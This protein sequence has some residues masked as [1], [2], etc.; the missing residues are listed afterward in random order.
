MVS[1]NRD[2]HREL[3][4]A[5]RSRGSSR[6]PLTTGEVAASLDCSRG[7]AHGGL[8]E[9]ASEGVLETK[10]VD[11]RSRIWWL[12]DDAGAT[13][14]APGFTPDAE[15]GSDADREGVVIVDAEE[16]VAWV[17]DA[18]SE[19]FGVDRSAAVGRARDEFLRAALDDRA[20]A[21]TVEELAA[22]AGDA[23]GDDPFAF[24]L[25]P[26]AD[27][28]VTRLRHAVEPIDGGRYAGGHVEFFTDVTDR[29]GPTPADDGDEERLFRSLV[30]ATTEY[31]IFT[32]DPD[33]HV[34]S[35][36]RGAER[37]KGY[38][39][40]EILGE[41]FSTFYTDEDVEAGVPKEN[42]SQALQEGSVE[43]EGWRVRADGS[44]F[45][46]NVTTTP[47]R[48]DDGELRGFAKVTRDITDRHEWERQIQEERNLLERTLDVVPSR[49]G[50]VSPDGEFLRVNDG[51]DGWFGTD[52]DDGSYGLAS[53]D[54]Y[55]ASGDRVPV[56]ER[57]YVEVFETGEPVSD[58][59]CQVELPDGSRRWFAVNAAPLTDDDG[60][61]EEVVVSGSDVTQIREQAE[62]L[63]ARHDDLE[64]E[65]DEMFE[66]VS[67]AF[68]G[69]DDEWRFTYVNERAEDVLG[70]DE[71]EFLGATIWDVFEDA[72]GTSSEERLRE[73]METQ[74][75]VHF[76]AHY[77]PLETCF[78]V[79]A[80]P[81]E[82]GLSVYFRDVTERKRRERV[83]E[84]YETL[85][86]ESQDV[87]AVIDPDG[88]FGYLP[89]ST[90]HVL[91]YE[92][93]ELAGERAFDYV[94]PDDR[95]EIRERLG[96][97]VEDP[98]R[99][100]V[101]EFRFR[102]ADGSWVV[103]EARARNL[104]DDPTIDGVVVY[105][106][107]VTERKERE[108]YQRELYEVT[109]SGD[110]PFDEKV[111]QL[112]DLGRE[113]FGLDV[114][115]LTRDEGDELRV[116]NAAGAVDVEE[117]V[118]TVSPDPGH[119]CR[120]SIG[121]DGPV[122]VEDVVASGWEEDPLYRDLGF[123]CYLGVEV[124]VGNDRYGTLCF[125]DREARADSFDDAQRTFLDLMGQ[126]VSYELERDQFE[127]TLQTLH[128]SSRELIRSETKSDVSRTVID[129]ATSVL[130]LEGVAAYRYDATD[131]ALVLDER[132]VEAG[133]MRETLPDFPA[134]HSSIVG[135]TFRE[136]EANYYDDVRESEH[137]LADPAEVDMEAGLFVPMD[138]HGVLVVGWPEGEAPDER[139]RR[140]VRILAA[141]AEAAYE[142]VERERRREEAE[143]RYRTLAENFP[144][145]AV[146]VYDDSLEFTLVEGAIWEDV[147]LDPDALEGEHVTEVV[148]DASADVESLYRDA[149]DG[150]PGSTEVRFGTDVFRV[151]ALP[152][153]DDAGDVSGGL[154]FAIDVTERV[155]RERELEEYETI[156]ETVQDGVYVLDEEFRFEKVNEAYAE[157]TGYDREELLGSHCSLVLGDEVSQESARRV[158][159]T[160]AEHSDGATVEADIHRADGTRL[161]AESNFSALPGNGGTAGR[162]GVVRDLTERIERER[163]LEESRRRYRT[164]VEN[165]PN[166]AVAMVDREMRYLTVGGE[167]I[168]EPNL[169]ADALVGT[170]V[171]EELPPELAEVFVPHYRR[172]LDGVETTDEIE[173]EGT[174]YKLRFV[175]VRDDD[176]EV[177]A[178]LG[179]SQDV[180]ARVEREREL[181]TRVDQHGVVADL[182]RRALGNPELDDLFADAV[183]RVAD[184]LDSEYCKVLDLDRESEELRLRS[185]VGWNEGYVGTATVDVDRDSQAGYTLLADEPVVV[186]DMAAE[187]RFAGP[188]LLVDHAVESGI[189]VVIGSPTD[190]WGVLGI[191][192]TEPREFSENDA[193]F[194]QSVA[195]VLATAID[196][197]EREVELEEQ[198]AHL[199]A[200]DDINGVV[201]DINEALV[202]QSTRDQI[203]RTVCERLADS[204]SYRFAWIAAVD[205]RTGTVEPRAEAG[206]DGYLD[207]VDVSVDDDAPEGQGPTGRAARTTEIQ[208]TNDALADPAYEP[209]RDVAEA[210]DFR[211]TAAIP[212]VYGDNLYGVLGVYTDR[213]GAF[214]DEE[215][216]VVAQLGEIVGHAIAAV[217]RK[218]A[219]MSDEVVEL[220]IRMENLLA[221]VGYAGPTEGRATFEDV[222]AIGDDEFLQYGTAVG[223]GIDAVEKLVDELPH[224]EECT[225]VGERFDEHRFELRL[226]EPPLVSAVADRGGYIDEAV[227]EDGSM[228]V[229]IHLPPTADVRQ[230]VDAIQDAYETAEMV[231]RQQVHRDDEER[232]IERALTEELTERQRAALEASFHAGFFEWPRESSGEEVAESLDVSAPT[233]HQ[234]L[235][236][237][238]QKL[239]ETILS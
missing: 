63:A 141:N 56:E 54:V 142:R 148:D 194:V 119:Y 155:E 88:T 99:S 176:C 22:R 52:G 209:W 186:E 128:E 152:I 76:E 3:L 205:P 71:G 204:D 197:R 151:W 199:A 11:E 221:E 189:S 27:E 238:Q 13:G 185:G 159:E 164:V 198:R 106:R 81:S 84:R 211:S 4:A 210:Y 163:E 218:R 34:I 49:I 233:F 38:D 104:L 95:E 160:I 182:G 85:F 143:R 16:T 173:V 195:N 12:A 137:L 230:T 202:E 124:T 20:D 130:D 157:M 45:W 126:W 110:V 92:P 223:G 226:S 72:A 111:D 41:H 166:G 225:V 31:A 206:V 112:I 82:S 129:A 102:H 29:T 150:T 138:D 1:R 67:N 93:G 87:N 73:A 170:H 127:E 46:A 123:A 98:D 116:M 149:L 97:V 156:V 122:G 169:S 114:G 222:V 53:D 174:V 190:P 32:L 109:A 167:F 40:S 235:R 100:P 125:V 78:E 168:A 216:E 181:Q 178:A 231:A 165:F 74:E 65:L 146:G 15:S 101:V 239:L 48:D 134:D 191:H 113:R 219:L 57:P 229:T 94:H 89:P 58:W 35:W 33:G 91:G 105:T 184:A 37:I 43:D 132:S 77:P 212:V 215:R 69:L 8:D 131:D 214:A 115:L 83:L 60:D 228:H 200:L 139:T 96:D 44:R 147:G 103:L 107:D 26:G 136:G 64:S 120:R 59:H 55:D 236:K 177:F 193:L 21:E 10:Q 121:S 153:R 192:D 175:P 2:G 66:R 30:E 158:E 14:D 108:R 187:E 135:H 172:A 5:F 62:R 118:T 23:P 207:E 213:V 42:L 180:T 47:I 80:Y 86:T 117:G 183:E 28:P 208:V 196:R 227:I 224:W 188:D 36:N 145:G 7:T 232:G 220:E 217:E 68:F 179:M 237:A 161:P 133:P 25:R 17:D 144:D 51:G 201:R 171:D 9:L 154:S 203:E 234:H 162:V 79:D 50:V 70:R 61:V 24:E 90:E 6:E 140:L 75:A 39:E 19:W 18:A